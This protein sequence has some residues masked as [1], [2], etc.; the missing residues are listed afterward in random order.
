M[1]MARTGGLVVSGLIGG[2]LL[3]VWLDWHAWIAND[4][5]PKDDG[6]GKN[7][8]WDVETW[9][10]A[11]L[12]VDPNQQLMLTL[13]DQPSSDLQFNFVD[14][15]NIPCSEGNKKDTCTIK[16]TTPG[17]IYLFGCKSGSTTYNCPDPGIKQ[18]GTT[19]N[20]G[21]R[22]DWLSYGQVLLTD[23]GCWFGCDLTKVRARWMIEPASTSK[24]DS[25]AT[26][27]HGTT[28]TKEVSAAAPAN[29]WGFAYCDGAPPNNSHVLPKNPTGTPDSPAT[30]NQ[31]QSFTWMSNNN[32]S[33]QFTQGSALCGTVNLG[34]SPSEGRYIAGCSVQSSAQGSYGY[35]ITVGN[36]KTAQESITVNPPMKKR[37]G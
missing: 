25:G 29:T 19:G 24:E 22:W 5:G 18:R 23:L 34:A 27:L 15:S 7:L 9:G 6:G 26:S 21:R 4:L 35:S 36:C 17:Q 8:H 32:F 12:L 33:I 16:S 30:V 31:N 13:S 3:G 10:D 28:P 2:V 20:G 11:N 14:T 1:G 37:K